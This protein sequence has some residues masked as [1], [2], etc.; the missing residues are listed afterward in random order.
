MA[1]TSA[2]AKKGWATRKKG[3]A[4]GLAKSKA[5]AAATRKETKRKAFAKK[6]NVRL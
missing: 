3:G 1:G 4:G 6:H 5:K 2:G